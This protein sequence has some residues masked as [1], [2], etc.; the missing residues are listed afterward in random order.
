VIRKIFLQMCKEVAEGLRVLI[1]FNLQRFLLYRS[2]GEL[3]Q[4]ER[5]MRDAVPVRLPAR[6]LHEPTPSHDAEVAIFN[7]TSQTV[8]SAD[9]AADTSW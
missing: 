4:Y 7:G 2:A 5:V 9:A 8:A 3:E 6:L 1:D